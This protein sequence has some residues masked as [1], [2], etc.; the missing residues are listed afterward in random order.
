MKIYI[1]TDME[2]ISGIRM[3]EQVQR[4]SPEYEDG[5]RLMIQDVNVAVDAAIS[6]GAKDVVVCDIHAGGGQVRVQEMDSR[7]CY[8]TPNC[9]LMM[10]SLD[11]S[12]NGLMLLGQHARAGTLNGF[13]DHTMR[14]QSWFEYRI[15]GQ[16]VGEVGI[17]AAIA[18]HYGVPVLVVTGDE[19]ACAESRE[20]LGRVECGV[21]KWAIGRNR[22]KCLSLPMAHDRIRTAIQTAMGAVTEYR[23]YKPSLPATVELTLY[24]SDMADELA[25]QPDVERIGARTI[26]RT[27]DSLLKIKA[28]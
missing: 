11:E 6:A 2:G 23:A 8:E 5:R 14:S 26:R 15:N 18:G 27:V 3:I 9:G 4:D 16:V 12:F 1:L 17:E 13:L 20:L 10:P 19:A 24:R 22:A 7:A 28:W 25:C 21:V